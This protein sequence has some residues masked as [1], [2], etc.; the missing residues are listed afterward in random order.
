MDDV[1]DGRTS[2]GGAGVAA[3]AAKSA[4]WLDATRRARRGAEGKL[5]FCESLV[6][7]RAAAQRVYDDSAARFRVEVSAA[8]SEYGCRVAAAQQNYL[9]DTGKLLLRSANDWRIIAARSAEELQQAVQRAGD[10]QASRCRA[11]MARACAE[12]AAAEDALF[13]VVAAAA[14]QLLTERIGRAQVE[15][16]AGA[17][18]TGPTGRAETAQGGAGQSRLARC[19]RA[20]VERAARADHKA[21]VPGCRASRPQ[22]QAADGLGSHLGGTG[23]QLRTPAAWVRPSRALGARGRCGGACAPSPCGPRLFGQ[24]PGR[25]PGG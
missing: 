3:R 2:A 12:G 17:A 11:A 5:A 21:S 9:R 4:P 13:S 18:C 15:V 7:A 19:G 6:S 16:G 14:A 22:V 8:A 24:P 20:R 23:E 25:P 1:Q 10:A